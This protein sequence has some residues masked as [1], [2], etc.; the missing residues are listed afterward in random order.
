MPRAPVPSAMGEQPCAARHPRAPPFRHS[1]HHGT[2]SVTRGLFPA[3][4]L[5]MVGTLPPVT[6]DLTALPLPRRPLDPRR[7]GPPVVRERTGLADGARGAPDLRCCC[8]VGVRFDVLDVP[9][10][11]GPGGA[12]PPGAGA[13]RWRC[14]ATGC[15]CWWPRAARRSCPGCWTGWS[16]ARWRWTSRRSAR[17]ALDARAAAPR[18]R[19]GAGGTAGA[20]G[21]GPLPGRPVQG[22]AVW[23]RPPEPGCEVEASLPTLSALGG[24]GGAPDLVRVVDT[25]AT[26]CHRLRLRRAV[27]AA[28]PVAGTAGRDQPLA[29]S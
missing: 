4:A 18:G 6:T 27:H 8:A 25:V 29:F 1:A 12:A 9:G 22:A 21:P 24:G 28:T 14:G 3:V 20:A 19:A 16:G 23:L 13:L 11:G 10:R 15:G 17:A 26:Q 7:S 5:G 2:P